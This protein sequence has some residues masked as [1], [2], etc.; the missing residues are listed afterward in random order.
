MIAGLL[1]LERGR[2]IKKAIARLVGVADDGIEN[3]GAFL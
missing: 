2:R 3:K 1:F